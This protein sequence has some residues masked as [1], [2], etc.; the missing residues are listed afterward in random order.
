MINPGTLQVINPAD[1]NLAPIHYHQGGQLVVDPYCL[2]QYLL[3]SLDL[4]Q[5]LRLL[6]IL[7]LLLPQTTKEQYVKQKTAVS[8][9]FSMGNKIAKLKK[10]KIKK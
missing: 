1:N 6:L 4:Q 10:H 7:F 5:G 9:V 8:S 2:V 3:K